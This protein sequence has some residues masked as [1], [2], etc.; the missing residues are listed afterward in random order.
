MCLTRRNLDPMWI[1]SSEE[2]LQECVTNKKG[3]STGKR[4]IWF[5]GRRTNRKT[6]EKMNIVIHG[7]INSVVLFSQDFTEGIVS[8]IRS[9]EVKKHQDLSGCIS[10]SRTNQ[11]RWN[12]ARRLLLW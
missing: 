1:L 3:K 5:N 9:D 8:E 12:P 2:I 6:G 11:T 4:S 7:L 10:V